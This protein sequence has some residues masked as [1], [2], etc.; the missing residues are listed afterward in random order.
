M[1]TRKEKEEKK[2]AEKKAADEAAEEKEAAERAAKAAE[3]EGVLLDEFVSGSKQGDD[4]QEWCTEQGSVLPTVEKLVFHLLTQKFTENPD[5]E[6]EWAEPEKFGTALLS[7][8][9][10]DADTQL[11]VLVAI[12]KYCDTLKFPK[13]NDEYLVQAMFRGMYKYDLSEAEVF[14]LW[15]EDEREENSQG[16]MKAVIQT[17]DWFNWLEE[18]D[19]SEE[20][21]YEEEE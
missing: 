3:A 16:K 17:M 2:A 4:L 9:E 19:E 15:K 8:V 14:D 11:S 1:G 20:E 13:V 6:C 18:D 12:Q 5:P 21:E 7:L 10:D